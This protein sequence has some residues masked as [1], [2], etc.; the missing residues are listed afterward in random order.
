MPEIAEAGTQ[1]AEGRKGTAI[2]ARVLA[3]EPNPDLARAMSQALDGTG[4][5]LRC[6][7]TFAEA[8]DLCGEERFDLIVVSWQVEGIFADDVL[9]MLRRM[10]RPDAMPAAMVLSPL[11]ADDTRE[12]LRRDVP[13]QSVLTRPRRTGDFAAWAPLF[14]VALEAALAKAEG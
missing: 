12:C 3:L 11:C 7:S 14:A 5:D 10:L 6:C 13:I 8:K 2:R 1:T 4:V 9:V